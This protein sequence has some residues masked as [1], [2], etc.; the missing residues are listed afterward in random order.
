MVRQSVMTLLLIVASLMAAWPVAAARQ[1]EL[2]VIL[3]VDTSVSLDDELRVLCGGIEELVADVEERGAAVNV[4]TLGIAETRDCASERVT[5]LVPEGQIQSK[6]DWGPAVADLAHHYEWTPDATRLV[7]PLS[8]EGPLR[9]DPVDD[10][11][12]EAI[13]QVIQ[14]ARDNEVMVSPLLG[15]NYNSDVEPLAHDLARKTGGQV[16]ATQNPDDDLLDGLRDLVLAAAERGRRATELL[17]AVPTPRDVVFEGAV[18]SA[19]LVLALL[20]T[21]VLGVASAVRENT[22][23]AFQA[24]RLGQLW[25]VALDAGQAA[26]EW[27][28]PMGWSRAPTRSQRLTMLAPWV[29]LLVLLA[30]VGIFLQP[31]INPLSWR[32]LG[33]WLRM[34]LALVLVSLIYEGGQYWI[35]RWSSM[36]P[37][38]RVRPGALLAS[39][40]GVMLSRAA[41]FVPGYF[42]TRLAV[43][44]ASP[45]GMEDD[46]PLQHWSQVSLFGLALVGAAGLSMWMLTL[47]TSL[48]NDFVEGIT[49]LKPLTGLLSGLVEALQGFFLIGFFVAWQTLFFEL[50]PLQSSAGA[51]L[52]RRNRL[53]WAASAFAVLFV[54]LHTLL[55]PLGASD[56]LLENR[57]LVLLLLSLFLYSALAVARWLYFARRSLGEE[58][59]SR[60]THESWEQDQLT[61]V[62]AISLI[63][64]WTLGVCYGLVRVAL[65]WLG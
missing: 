20:L 58:A 36:A 15:N 56:E 21:V 38:L 45:E 32:G 54:L 41:G 59:V 46:L 50:L 14:A 43:C 60:A 35:A 19:N 30:L 22:Q 13:K 10:E 17:K 12:K 51:V 49:V 29:L 62:M 26:E 3:L 61:A 18:V 27:T 57:G 16:F 2:D 1:V 63:V 28:S 11:D 8:D 65:G 44:T 9:G 53:M 25:A 23:A 64:I 4:V 33:L 42:Y 31:D 37:M 47:P 24:S 40:A 7:I 6:E 34:L 39:V 48:L 5:G 55:N 52:Y